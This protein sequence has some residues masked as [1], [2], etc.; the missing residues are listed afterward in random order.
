[1]CAP[2][3]CCTTIRVNGKRLRR[4]RG[5]AE[6]LAGSESLVNSGADESETTQYR[7]LAIN[8]AK[9]KPAAKAMTREVIGRSSIVPRQFSTAS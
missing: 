5:V 2:W 3:K 4:P 1:M 6:A 9:T 7:L 8:R